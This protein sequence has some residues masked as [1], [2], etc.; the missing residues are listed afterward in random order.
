MVLAIY[1]NLQCR[2]ILRGFVGGSGSG[3]CG[4]VDPTAWGGV[5]S[6]GL[7]CEVSWD[8]QAYWVLQSVF[9]IG[10]VPIPRVRSLSIM[11]ILSILSIFLPM[12]NSL[13]G[14]GYGLYG[15]YGHR[16]RTSVNTC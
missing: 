2:F 16:A 13:I 1:N 15:L 7:S 10:L 11:S 12:T 8:G 6:A 9:C 3:F 4:L 5:C 14:K